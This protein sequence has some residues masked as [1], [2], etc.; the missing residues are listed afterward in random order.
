[1]K[2]EF[3]TITSDL[4][5]MSSHGLWHD[6]HMR[7]IK[8]FLKRDGNSVQNKRYQ[9]WASIAAQTSWA[10]TI[11]YNPIT[12]SYHLKDASHLTV[13]LQLKVHQ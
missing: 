6:G 13:T 4:S 9:E 5:G 11:L 1:M 7:T 3:L 10:K 8:G 2:S 12:V